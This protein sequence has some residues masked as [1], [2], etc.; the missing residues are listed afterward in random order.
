MYFVYSYVQK[1]VY[2]AVF[3]AFKMWQQFESFAWYTGTDENEEM[4]NFWT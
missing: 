2:R 1:K 4:V 3:T